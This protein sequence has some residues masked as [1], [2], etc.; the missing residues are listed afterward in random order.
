MMLSEADFVVPELPRDSL[1]TNWPTCLAPCSICELLSEFNRVDSPKV[2][3]EFKRRSVDSSN[4]V[5]S[6][7]VNSVPIDAVRGKSRFCTQPVLSFDCDFFRKCKC[8]G[9]VNCGCGYG[10]QPKLPP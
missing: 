10:P 1:C 2:I 5:T 8:C 9:A 4:A 7:M 3:S 6:D